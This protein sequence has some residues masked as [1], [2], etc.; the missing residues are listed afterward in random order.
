[1]AHLLVVNIS[2]TRQLS[3]FLED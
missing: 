3:N 2:Q 1:M